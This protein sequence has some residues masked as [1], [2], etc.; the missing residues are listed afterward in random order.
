MPMGFTATRTDR[1]RI[2]Q[3]AGW[4]SAIL[5][6]AYSFGWLSFCIIFFIS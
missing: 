4:A 2:K 3:Q 6:F 5:P 1:N